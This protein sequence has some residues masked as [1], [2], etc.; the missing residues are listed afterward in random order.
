MLSRAISVSGWTRKYSVDFG[1]PARYR[2]Q[3]FGDGYTILL[4]AEGGFEVRK[5]HT[6]PRV[7]WAA[8]QRSFVDR[9]PQRFGAVASER[10]RRRLHSQSYLA[11]PFG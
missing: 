9:R 11:P 8:S 6:L 4:E 10:S 7:L 2:Y 1:F 3:Q 5:R